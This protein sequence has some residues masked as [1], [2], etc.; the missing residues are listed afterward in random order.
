[1]TLI[2]KMI[3]YFSSDAIEEAHNSLLVK[4]TMLGSGKFPLQYLAEMKAEFAL[5]LHLWPHDVTRTE[6]V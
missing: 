2:I 3:I 6:S 4:V 1:M 5:G